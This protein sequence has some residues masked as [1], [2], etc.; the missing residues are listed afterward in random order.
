M[1][2]N[3]HHNLEPLL[4]SFLLV[5]RNSPLRLQLNI[6]LRPNHIANN[7][8]AV[9]LIRERAKFTGTCRE[10][11]G[12]FWTKILEGGGTSFS[13]KNWM[14]QSLFLIKSNLFIENEETKIF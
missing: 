2:F 13:G 8:L 11:L 9:L 4:V 12:I 7:Q 14:Q 6:E 10:E 1:N 5:H 3:A